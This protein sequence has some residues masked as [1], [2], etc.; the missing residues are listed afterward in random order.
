M[1]LVFFAVSGL[2]LLGAL[3]TLSAKEKEEVVNWI[4]AQQILP[5]EDGDISLCGFRGSSFI[6][7][8]FEV[9]F[10]VV[11]II[12]ITSRKPVLWTVLSRPLAVINIL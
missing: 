1:T 2:D 12:N 4:Y 11:F 7:A 9:F 3:E 10:L 6:G 8:P 5:G